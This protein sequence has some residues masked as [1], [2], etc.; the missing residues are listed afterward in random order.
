[1]IC[2]LTRMVVAASL[3]AA[4]VLLAA[5][6]AS[7]QSFEDG[8]PAPWVF[9][10]DFYSTIGEITNERAYDGSFSAKIT[11]RSTGNAKAAFRTF[12]S[13]RT[14]SQGDVLRFWV[15]VESG[16]ETDIF[17]LKPLIEYGP[18]FSNNIFDSAFYQ[19][20]GEG[21]DEFQVGQWHPL[22]YE[23]PAEA[24]GENLLTAGIELEG[25]A[26][27]VSPTIYV[28]DITLAGTPLP[29]ELV[30]FD[31][32]KNGKDVT[33]EWRTASETNNA[34]FAVLHVAP[35]AESAQELAFVDGA[36]TTTEAQS[37]SYSVNDLS[38]GTHRF[39]LRQTDL[40]GATNLSDP[41]AV[42]IRADETSLSLAGGNPFSQATQVRYSVMESG[43]VRIGLYD[44]MGRRVRT[45]F[46]GTH[47]QG[48]THTLSV[49]G[50]DLAPG[51]YFLR[52][53]T[54]TETMT[55]RL[56]VVK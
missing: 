46:E 36:G 48:T 44:I 10:D 51:V 29:V 52:L 54:D 14:L 9:S 40:D 11:L 30:A 22:T 55:R 16:Q 19:P 53:N 50:T 13:G 1:M 4:A 26:D 17:A 24:D 5:G 8:D 15:Y 18:D 38:P 32:V 37:Y 35:G 27:D 49:D 39:R 25:T 31:V 28:D 45:L 34:G 33:L 47:A 2:A 23:V 20:P 7:A 6:S 21:G 56:T 42:E 43:P 12:P 3:F 41:I